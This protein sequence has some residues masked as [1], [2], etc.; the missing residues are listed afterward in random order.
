MAGNHLRLP[1][2]FGSRLHR[3]KSG[4]TLFTPKG[5]YVLNRRDLRRHQHTRVMS[6]RQG[7]NDA[8]L[9]VIRNAAQTRYPSRDAS[10]DRRRRLRW[11]VC[12]RH[13]DAAVT[14]RPV[15]SE[16]S[17]I[18]TMPAP[19]RRTRCHRVRAAIN[20]TG[21]ITLRPS[22]F[23]PLQR[24]T[25]LLMAAPSVPKHGGGQRPLTPG[26][27]A[28]FLPVKVPKRLQTAYARRAKELGITTSELVRTVLSGYIGD[29]ARDGDAA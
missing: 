24:A 10:S 17:C 23:S 14:P 26:E 16:V 22:A 9:D 27:V 3:R 5:R 28:V 1:R 19:V 2:N 29:L 6:A 25:V 8:S 4:E 18:A 15:S 7:Q 13:T 21:G 20:H 11:F 12:N